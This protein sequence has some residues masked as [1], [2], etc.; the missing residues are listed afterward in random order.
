MLHKNLQGMGW[1]GTVK[2]SIVDVP[3]EIYGVPFG[4]AAIVREGKD[5]TLVGLGVT[6]HMALD[7]AEELAKDGINAEVIDLRS[8]VPLDRE[9]ICN[10]VA[11]TGRLLVID[12]DYISYG[13]TGEIISSVAERDSSVFKTSPR[14]IAYP[15][16]PVPFT[17]PMEQFALPNKDKIFN[18]V[19]EMMRA[20]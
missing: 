2:N 9:T 5:I 7:A 12:D 15:D 18:T 1:L 14:R 10:S 11:K 3:K 13:V 19:K 20:D 8:L 17:R 16:I 4:K 6:V